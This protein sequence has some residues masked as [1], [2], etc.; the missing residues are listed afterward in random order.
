MWPSGLG[1]TATA[2]EEIRG[3][4]SPVEHPLGTAERTSLAN[5]WP[6]LVAGIDAAPQGPEM[7]QSCEALDECF[8]MRHGL[9]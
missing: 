6:H 8:V 2:P 1:L 5:N 9:R 4:I 3:D 7:R